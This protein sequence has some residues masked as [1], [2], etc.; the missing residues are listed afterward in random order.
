MSSAVIVTCCGLSWYLIHQHAQSLKASLI[1]TGTLLAKQL[2]TTSLFNVISQ[3]RIRLRLLSDSTLSIPETR[4]VR[5]FDTAN[6]VVFAKHKTP[7]LPILSSSPLNIRDN[8]SARDPLVTPYQ[9]HD[10]QIHTVDGALSAPQLVLMVLGVPLPETI[11]DVVC[12]IQAPHQSTTLDQSLL[13]DIAVSSQSRSP[14]AAS[15]GYV[16]LGISNQNLQRQLAETT[17]QV[18]VRTAVIILFGVLLAIFVS[19]RLTAPVHTLA[20]LAK[21]VAKGNLSITVQPTTTDEIGDLTQSFNEMVQ[22]LA[23]RDQTLAHQLQ[24]LDTIN[25]TGLAVTSS[26]NLT[27]LMDVVLDLVVKNLGFTQTF[28]MLYDSERH[29]AFGARASGIPSD[30]TESVRNMTIPIQHEEMLPA[31]VLLSGQPVLIPDIDTSISRIDPQ[32]LKL[33]KNLDATSFILVPLQ[34]QQG[35]QGFAG[36]SRGTVMCTQADLDLLATIGGQVGAAIDNAQAYLKLENMTETLELQVQERTEELR[37]ANEKLRELDRIKSAVVTSASHELR[38][39][40]TSI[41][42]HVDNVLDGGTGPLGHE[43]KDFLTRVRNNTNRLRRII[44]EMLDLS[45]IE[46]GQSSLNLS[47][48]SFS[49][50]LTDVLANLQPLVHKQH[51]EIKT[52]CDASLPSLRVDADKLHQILTNLIHNAI[53]FSSPEG[54]IHMSVCKTQDHLLQVCIADAGPGIPK[55]D[56][57]KI[58]LPFYRSPLSVIKGRGAGLGLAITKALLELQGGDLWVDSKPGSGSQFFFTLPIAVTQPEPD[59]IGTSRGQNV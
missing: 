18:L 44:N 36:A 16:Q 33:V 51:I 6:Q 34:S 42:M 47:W 3:D 52:F 15:Y 48:V 45:R 12:L 4:Y 19:A 23:H 39:P 58:F 30:V 7:E 25:Q 38:T 40:L 26:L 24:R 41:Q 27:T 59:T 22:A 54:I 14:T 32:L 10:A 49:E 43:Q 5:F 11:F 31:T 46:S 17:Q 1:H 57:P 21:D 55:E 35:I 56:L 53:K 9:V 29:E 13:E 8:G 37:Q 2:A 28:L 20:S 50:V